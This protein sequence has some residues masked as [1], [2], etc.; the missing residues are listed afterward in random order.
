MIEFKMPSL[1]AD[2]EDGILREWRVKPGDT[3]KRGDIIAEVEVQKG[4]IDIECFDDGIIEALLVKE[5]EKVPVGIVMALIRSANEPATT[6]VTAPVST[7]QTNTTPSTLQEIKAPQLSAII[8]QTERSPVFTTSGIKATPL[9]KRIAAEHHIDLST[10]KGTGDEGAITKEDVEKAIEEG[11]SS[12]VPPKNLTPAENIRLA[13]AAAMSK[14]NREIPHYYLEKKVDVTKALAW[15]TE[16]NA[17][18]PIQQRLLQVVLFIKAGAKALKDVPELNAVWENGL[19]K[20]EGI[21]IG[22]VVS[23]KGGGIMVPAIHDVDKK[24]L[25]EIMASLNDLIP[26]ARA[27]KLRSSELSDSTITMTSLGEG[28]AD[29]VYGVIY[30]PQVAIIGIGGV[31]KEITA[32]NGENWEQAYIY[33]TLAGDHRATDGLT[34]SKFL[35]AFHHYLQQ[36]ESL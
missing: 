1:G 19:I 12:E 15:L 21:H 4:N 20:K 31:I 25:D 6:T 8:E 17:Q 3:V 35:A 14:S 23:L 32:T 2:M 27:L 13:V 16:Q 9:A 36:P 30:P 33:A 29:K 26:R 11:I 10:L 24:S 22:F 18:R 34:G 5:N 7:I 28:G